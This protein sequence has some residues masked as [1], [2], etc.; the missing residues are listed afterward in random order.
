MLGCPISSSKL[1]FQSVMVG[2]LIKMLLGCS[3]SNHSLPEESSS[4]SS[5][6]GGVMPIP[7]LITPPG[8]AVTAADAAAAMGAGFNL[9][10]TFENAQH[11]RTFFSVQPKIDAYYNMGYR[12]IRVPI[13]WTDVVDGDTLVN[14]PEVGDVNVDHPRLNEIAQVIDYALSLPGMYVIINA[15]HERDLKNENKWWVLERLW[16]DIATVFGDRDYRLIFQ[17]LNEPH[18]NNGDPMPA[19]SLRFMSG[20]AYDKIRSV[21]PKRIVLIGGN[22]WFAAHEMAQVWPNLD[23]VGGGEDPYVMASFHHYNPWDFS[24]DSRENYAYP[25]TESDLYTPIDTMLNWA[26]GVGKGMPIYIGEWGVGWQS[27]LATMDCNN[28]RQWYAQM[29]V[30]NAAPRGVPTSVWDDGGWFKVFDHRTNVFD[31]DL[32]ACLI[33]GSCGWTGTER[34]NNACFP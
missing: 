11:P 13:T 21:N 18:L 32:A 7:E 34:F 20:K 28:I 6:S 31:N 23:P 30:H 22:R 26:S 3:S 33:E 25:W 17:L 19:A 14:D 10:Q 24:G 5:S 9:G 16:T 4:S 1:Q 8:E 15:H 29:H 27:T 2:L 12:N